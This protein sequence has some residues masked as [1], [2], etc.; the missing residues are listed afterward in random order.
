MMDGH[1]QLRNAAPGV[2]IMAA[3]GAAFYTTASGARL[4]C[5]GAWF[6]QVAR[7]A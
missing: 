1:E 6:G 4:N 7:L 5:E 2:S 3:A